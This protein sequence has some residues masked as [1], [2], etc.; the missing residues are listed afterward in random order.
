MCEGEPLLVTER[1]T[2][3]AMCQMAQMQVVGR[4]HVLR[5]ER[6]ALGETQ[7]RHLCILC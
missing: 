7:G 6:D 2:S 5:K 3:H 4:V 1:C